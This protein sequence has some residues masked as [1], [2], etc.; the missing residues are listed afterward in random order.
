MVAC[1]ATVSVGFAARSRHFS[2]FGGAKIGAS[3]TL[4]TFCARPKF[5]AFKKR[6]VLQT[7]K[8]VRKRLLCGLTN[9]RNAG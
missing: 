3:A 1:V 6:K 2:L 9:S 4:L 8:A 5:R 7:R